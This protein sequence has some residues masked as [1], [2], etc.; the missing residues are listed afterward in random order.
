MLQSWCIRTMNPFVRSQDTLHLQ[1]VFMYAYHTIHGHTCTMNNNN[2]NSDKKILTS[3][4]YWSH[5]LWVLCGKIHQKLKTVTIISSSDTSNSCLYMKIASRVK[6]SAVSGH[7]SDTVNFTSMTPYETAGKSLLLSRTCTI[8]ND[9]R[10][11]W[12]Y[13][14]LNTLHEHLIHNSSLA[15]SHLGYISAL[16][17]PCHPRLLLDYQIYCGMG[18]Y[19]GLGDFALIS[20]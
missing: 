2:S 12:R 15:I 5:L 19:Q 13:K 3:Q 17:W 20:I 8:L 9:Q 7:T 18:N 10:M 6:N 4:F 16:H 1:R 11:P 14:F